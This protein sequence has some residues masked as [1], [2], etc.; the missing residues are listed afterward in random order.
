M[1]LFRTSFSISPA[2]VEKQRTLLADMPQE[3]GSVNALREAIVEIRFVGGHQFECVVDKGFDGAL[4]VPASVAK[5]FG[6]SIVARLVF[7]LVGGARMGA[8]VALGEI[9][10]LGQRRTVEVILS[11]G[12]DALIG[13]ELFEGAKLIVDYAKGVV[14]I[15][16]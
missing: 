11:E 9:E 3:S 15:S 10:W 2:L 7:E 8:D 6:L 14:T 4:I 16:R 5:R 13:T 12:D 1:L